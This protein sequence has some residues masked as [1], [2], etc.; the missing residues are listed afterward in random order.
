MSNV[1]GVVWSWEI[2][3]SEVLTHVIFF[4]LLCHFIYSVCLRYRNVPG[5]KNTL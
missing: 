5:V 3:G 1:W 4:F 2:L